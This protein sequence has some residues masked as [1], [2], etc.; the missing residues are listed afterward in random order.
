M[1]STRSAL[2]SRSL[3]K[4]A[5]GMSLREVSLLH[6]IA[7]PRQVFYL[8]MFPEQDLEVQIIKKEIMWTIE[9]E[10][11]YVYDFYRSECCLV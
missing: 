4:L 7:A 10:Q 6:L 3:N 11:V 2:A 1:C 5:G 8:S 9:S